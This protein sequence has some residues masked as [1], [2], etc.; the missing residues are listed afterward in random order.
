VC[1][2]ATLFSCWIC[3]PFFLFFFFLLSSFIF[4]VLGVSGFD[5]L[6]GE[7]RV[8]V[9]SVLP[10]WELELLLQTTGLQVVV[11]G[12]G[13]VSEATLAVGGYLENKIKI[14]SF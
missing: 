14:K 8:L 1:A 5:V 13:G 9:D 11:R 10:T 4:L 2:V 6:L 3:V 7:Q 12:K